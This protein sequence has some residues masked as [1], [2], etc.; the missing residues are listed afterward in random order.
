[1]FK[2]RFFVIRF[3]AALLTNV[4]LRKLI[5]AAIFRVDVDDQDFSGE[6]WF[7]GYAKRWGIKYCVDVGA[8]VGD[9]TAAAIHILGPQVSYYL[10]EPIPRHLTA[11]Q[12]RFANANVS[13]LPHAV[14]KDVGLSKF[15]EDGVF[16]SLDPEH[17]T[18]DVQV[19]N[20]TWLANRLPI[21]D[22]WLLK[23]DVEGWDDQ[24]LNEFMAAF[25]S[26]LALIQI[27]L[28]PAQRAR[29]IAL[30]HYSALLPGHKAFLVSGH[31]LLDAGCMSLIEQGNPLLNVAFVPTAWLNPH[32]QP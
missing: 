26:S 23:I 1:M 14:G 20:R 19:V 10:F 2:V 25:N 28:G 12:Q 29:G 18:T 3:L 9:W 15:R 11:L 21:H 17:G 6:T 31:G 30:E 32:G 5:T 13:I 8:N 4:K 22:K 7:M 24:V 27:E 16:S